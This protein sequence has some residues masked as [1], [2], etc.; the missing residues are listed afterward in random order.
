M[1]INDLPVELTDQIIRPFCVHCA[2]TKTEGPND[3]EETRISFLASL[4]L[5]SRRLNIT[6]TPHLYHHLTGRK[7]PLLARTLLARKDLTQFPTALHFHD[8]WNADPSHSSPA[9]VDYFTTHFHDWHETLSA[10]QKETFSWQLH[11]S[12]ELADMFA[13]PFHNLPLDITASLCPNLQTITA[14]LASDIP[15]FRFNAPSSLPHLHTA[16]FTHHDRRD[17][18]ID[19]PSLHPLLHAAPHLT[20]L[21]LSYFNGTSPNP[22]YYSPDDDDPPPPL[23]PPT[24]LT[25][26]QLT[27]LDLR[28]S[29]LDVPSLRAILTSCPRLQTLKCA[30]GGY[31]VGEG[32]FSLLE[33]AEVVEGCA[34]ESLGLFRMSVA[35]EDVVCSEEWQ[36]EDVPEVERRLAERGVCFQ[37]SWGNM[38]GVVW[39][40]GVD[41]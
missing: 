11:G 29:V 8:Y 34:P 13:P 15:T 37:F 20:T 23:F 38:D 41:G 14:T 1:G 6:A 16:H 9:L 40:G 2:P 26:L 25:P 36:E 7:W 17:G 39:R 21:T 10:T 19:L 28:H 12:P 33:A 22:S 3:T 24:T 32:D 18:G 27:H 35:D 30:W 5:L 4:C 31:S